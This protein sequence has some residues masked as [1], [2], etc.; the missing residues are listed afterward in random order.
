MSVTTGSRTGRFR[1]RVLAADDQPGPGGLQVRAPR[2]PR[3]GTPK[4]PA[5]VLTARSTSSDSGG[6]LVEAPLPV[7]RRRTG[8]GRV[9]KS[10]T[11]HG[12][13]HVHRP[14]EDGR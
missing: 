6:G 5:P 3:D 1:D 7:P 9:P 11:A 13:G 14:A 12:F 2:G 8:P 10:R 4:P